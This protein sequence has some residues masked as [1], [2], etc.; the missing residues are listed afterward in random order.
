MGSALWSIRVV[1]DRGDSSHGPESA[2]SGFLCSR[3]PFCAGWRLCTMP[4]QVFVWDMATSVEE[5]AVRLEQ[6]L[7]AVALSRNGKC[8]AACVDPGEPSL[9]LPIGVIEEARRVTVGDRNGLTGD[10]LHTICRN[11]SAVEQKA[12]NTGVPCRLRSGRDCHKMTTT[13]R[14]G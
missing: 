2:R 3:P 5:R 11:N 7:S 14:G 10:R 4:G 6:L 1:W 12:F 13:L 9:L 8:H